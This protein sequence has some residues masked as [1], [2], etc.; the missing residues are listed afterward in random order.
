M[1]EVVQLWGYR[2]QYLGL[3]LLI[4]DVSEFLPEDPVQL[5]YWIVQN[6]Q[7]CLEERLK[8]LELNSAMERLK[9]EL[10]L[11]NLVSENYREIELF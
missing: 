1:G 8:I 2:M 11:L 9:L 5:S 7:L 4:I 10:L 6:Y 3:F